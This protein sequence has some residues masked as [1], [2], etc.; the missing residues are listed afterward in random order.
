[1]YRED[2]LTLRIDTSWQKCSNK[3]DKIEQLDRTTELENIQGEETVLKRLVTIKRKKELGGNSPNN[4]R[5]PPET[6]VHAWRSFATPA[7]RKCNR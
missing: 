3:A 6:P 4:H 2:I 7:L 5:R 1:M